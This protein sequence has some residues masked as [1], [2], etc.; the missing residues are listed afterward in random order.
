MAFYIW[1]DR[2]KTNTD[3]YHTFVFRW[4]NTYVTAFANL[5]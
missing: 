2:G 4:V 1:I 5:G 3:F